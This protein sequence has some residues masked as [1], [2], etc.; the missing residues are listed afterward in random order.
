MLSGPAAPRKENSWIKFHAAGKRKRMLER[1]LT[2]QEATKELAEEVICSLH[3][4]LPLGS[5]LTFN[6][7]IISH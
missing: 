3:S 5:A 7:L 2:S 6:F 4:L 1:G